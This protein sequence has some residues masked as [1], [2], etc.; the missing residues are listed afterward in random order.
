MSSRSRR[1]RNI[2]YDSEE[3]E[4][5]PSKRTRGR[6]NNTETS[7]PVKRSRREP[8]ESSDSSDSSQEE[9][10]IQSSSLADKT[11]KKMSTE[12]L[13]RK[14]KEVVRLA[15]A[16]ELRKVPLRREEVVRKVLA[17]HS[18]AFPV[19]LSKAREKLSDIFGMDLV[20][21]PTKEKPTS[22]RRRVTKKENASAKSFML[23]NTLPKKLREV[24]LIN[25]D[26]NQ[27]LEKMGLLTVILSLIH[28]N[29]RILSDDQLNHYFR[30]LRL[31]DEPLNTTKLIATF[32]KQGYLNKQKVTAIENSRTSEKD[33]V[34][35]RWGPRAKIE[36]S[37]SSIC[38]F[39]KGVYGDDALPDL[40]KQIERA[41]GLEFKM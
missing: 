26:K 11:V 16:C 10:N 23:R 34:E 35:Y 29:G 7:R 41:S 8:V 38:D 33:P 6:Q 3:E 2:N 12:E 4:A 15:L 32:I 39:I 13:D 19:V 18:R 1:N 27:E 37:E 5:G 40:P 9:L 31:G 36:F 21:M 14:V 28:V 17:D 25:W 22:A 20:E 24:N 30:R